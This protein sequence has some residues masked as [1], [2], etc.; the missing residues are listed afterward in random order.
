MKREHQLTQ[1]RHKYTINQRAIQ[2]QEQRSNTQAIFDQTIDRSRSILKQSQ[3]IVRSYGI[4][5]SIF[6]RTVDRSRSMLNQSRSIVR[7]YGINTSIFDRMIDCVRY[8][9][10]FRSYGLN[11]QAIPTR[12]SI[13][14]SILKLFLIDRIDTQATR[15]QYS[16]NRDH[17]IF[18]SIK[19]DQF[20]YSSVAF[21]RYQYSSNFLCD[22]VRYS[23]KFFDR[24]LKQ[25]RRSDDRDSI[26][27]Q[28]SCRVRLISILKQFQYSSD[29]RSNDRSH[30]YSSK[31]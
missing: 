5:T 8:S 2:I 19:C 26:D 22:R 7:S 31:R 24:V 15:D 29:I 9:S 16:S 1:M 13:V 23:S 4:N 28:V 3:S 21:D 27:T 18:R 12:R 11:T 25:S 30:L 17:E 6:D 14:I 10:I 20:Q